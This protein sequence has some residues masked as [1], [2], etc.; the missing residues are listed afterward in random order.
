MLNKHQTFSP[1][2]TFIS[3]ISQRQPVIHSIFDLPIVHDADVDADDDDDWC[4]G[5]NVV[6]IVSCG[7]VVVL[8]SGQKHFEFRYGVGKIRRGM[9][10]WWE[11]STSTDAVCVCVR[12]SI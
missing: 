11:W 3:F 8:K 12:R 2:F 6:F 10:G 9:L 7:P 5:V 4:G 1:T